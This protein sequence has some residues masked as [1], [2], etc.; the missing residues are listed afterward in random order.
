MHIT[1]VPNRIAWPFL[2]LFFTVYACRPDAGHL[3]NAEPSKREYSKPVVY[4][5]MVRLFGNT[6]TTN[7]RYGT[8]GENGVGKFD[9]ITPQALIELRELGITHVWYTGV[10]EHATMTDYS[11]FGIEPDDPDVVKG[12]AG[13]PYAIR[14]YYDV[15]PDL[16][17]AVPVRREEFRDLLERSHE[18]GL[19]VI[20]DFVP[21][22]VARTYR[23]DT[24]PGRV[25]DLGQSDDPSLPF[26]TNNNFYYLPGQEFR[27]PEGYDPLPGEDHPLKDGRFHESPA[28]AT[29]NDVFT[30]RPS[31]DDW[32]ET[33]KLNYG[34]DYSAGRSTHFDP[35]PDTWLKMAD[36]LKHWAALGVGGFRC[37]MAEMVPVEFWDWAISGVKASFPGTIFIAEIYNPDLYEEYIHRGGFDFLYDKVQLYDSL[38]NIVAGRTGTDG[39]PDVLRFFHERGIDD[40]MLRFLENHDEQRI[41][42]PYFAGDP[43]KAW[44]AMVVSATVSN[45]PVMIYFGQE[46][47]EP[48][49][50]EEGFQGEDGRTTIFDYWGVP[51]HQKWVNGGKYDGGLL[52]DD[53]RRLRNAYGRLLR[54][55]NQYETLGSGGFLDL[56]AY[57]QG[58]P[59]GYRHSYVYSFLR[60]AQDQHIAVVANFSDSEEARVQ[61]M[62]PPETLNLNSNVKAREVLNEGKTRF[63]LNGNSNTI[64]VQLAPLETA[65]F[66]LDTK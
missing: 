13:S 19:K 36:I 17:V 38:R 34:V 55:C 58:Q 39:L 41:A 47:G 12:R 42:S 49:A 50:G 7:R 32:F 37:D 64:Y 45:G 16:A 28:K 20:I 27:V 1:S 51:E 26:S 23:S 65:V 18:Y 31:I 62:V 53:Q 48:G 22:H 14:D 63:D 61:V 2:V 5:I 30:P 46:V 60:S 59:A 43:W 3:G 66:V 44:P 57:N 40:Y 52:G 21:N 29:G 33:V 9:D 10:L 15:S 35:I 6:T 25:E 54:M 8:A 24:N 11:R 56:H 4:Q